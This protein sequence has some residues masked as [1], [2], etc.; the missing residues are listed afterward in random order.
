ML[1]AQKTSMKPTAL[2]HLISTNQNKTL[3][4]ELI[5]G[6]SNEAEEA[7]EDLYYKQ[8]GLDLGDKNGD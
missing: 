3:R 8:Q 7:L 6:L 2:M 5:T 4:E 1:K